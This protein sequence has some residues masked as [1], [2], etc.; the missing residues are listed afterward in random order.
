MG[1]PVKI[2]RNKYEVQFSGSVPKRN[3]VGNNGVFQFFHGFRGT[4]LYIARGLGYD[5]NF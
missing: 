3:Q 4:K 1:T 5:P 2:S